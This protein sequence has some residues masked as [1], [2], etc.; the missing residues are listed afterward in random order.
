M[1]TYYISDTWHIFRV[2]HISA[3]SP[4]STRTSGERAGGSRKCEV[5]RLPA[6][7]VNQTLLDSE[8][9]AWYNGGVV[10]G[11]SSSYVANLIDDIF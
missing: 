9:R 7:T 11:V 3:A 2:S 1:S 10:G 8:F 6:Y 4:H 5:V